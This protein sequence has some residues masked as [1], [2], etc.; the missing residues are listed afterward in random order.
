MKAK[1]LLRKVAKAIVKHADQF[2]MG[3]WYGKSLQ[4]YKKYK[5]DPD[6]Y[7]DI[8]VDEGHKFECKEAID[9]GGCGTAACI[10]GWINYIAKPPKDKKIETTADE[11][12]YYAADKKAAKN[13]GMDVYDLDTLFY[14]GY[15]PNDLRIRYYKAKT[16]EVR[17][18]I[19]A[20]RIER[21]I[22]E[23]D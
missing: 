8:E 20:E 15:W 16:P 5:D 22:K 13:L 9:A 10:G 11:V 6:S 4:F 21:F 7:P 17:A 19:A 1:Q 23:M 12:G 14:L 3:D 18:K 2:D